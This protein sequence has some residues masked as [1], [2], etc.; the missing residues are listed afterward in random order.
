MPHIYFG[1]DRGESHVTA[2]LLLPAMANG[3]GA[4]Q[5]V[6]AHVQLRHLENADR[7]RPLR[8]IVV[9]WHIEEWRKLLYFDVHAYNSA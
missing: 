8:S 7:Q 6:L 3:P 2:R 9:Q 1:V 5:L 4:V